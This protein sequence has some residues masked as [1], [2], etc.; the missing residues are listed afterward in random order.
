MICFLRALSSAMERPPWPGH[1][2]S[3]V[4]FT[5]TACTHVGSPT[6]EPTVPAGMTRPSC[7]RKSV[8]RGHVQQRTG[9]DDVVVH[10][11][12]QGRDIGEGGHGPQPGD[13]LDA[14]VLA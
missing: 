7:R 3:P 6:S 13:E 1:V 2:W 11:R 10:R 9:A 4:W 5:G 14:D 12:D 8:G